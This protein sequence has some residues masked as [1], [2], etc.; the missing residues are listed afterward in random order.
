MPKKTLTEISQS[1]FIEMIESIR[2][3][4][5]EERHSYLIS[6]YGEQKTNMLFSMMNKLENIHISK[7]VR[8]ILWDNGTIEYLVRQ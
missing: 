4:P 3:I 7:F 6:K 1:K 8:A 2:N 5:Y